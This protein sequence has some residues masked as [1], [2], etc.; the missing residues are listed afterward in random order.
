MT[1]LSRELLLLPTPWHWFVHGLGLGQ[2]PTGFDAE[3]AARIRALGRAV[4]QRYGRGFPAF[5]VELVEVILAACDPAG[6][7]GH[8]RDVCV[9][10]GERIA[11]LSNPREHARACATS[12]ESLV[13]LGELPPDNEVLRRQLCDSLARMMAL[14]APSDRARYEHVHLLANLLL[15]AAR[16]G[17]TEL[18]T[19][20]VFE[21]GARLLGPV[22]DLFYYG[23][24]A[25]TWATT[26]AAVGRR[27]GDD[28]GELL[29]RVLDRI[30]TELD[31]P[32]DRASDGAHEDRD[33]L[34]FSLFLA[35][36][37]IGMT[38][39]VDLLDYKRRWLEVAPAE[40]ASL[41]P[42]ARS[43][44]TL[45]F[46]SLLRNLGLLAHHVPDPA[47]LVRA[48]AA[49][50]LAA[51]DGYQHDDYLRCTYLVHIARQLDCLT[52]LPERIGQIL[53]ETSTQLGAP[54]PHRDTPY[55]SP[56]MFVA[57]V[58]SAMHADDW[59]AKHPLWKVDLA[60]IVRSANER[61]DDVVTIPRIGFALID[62]ALCLRAS[63]D[64]GSELLSP[65]AV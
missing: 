4:M 12:I 53:A 29:R 44:Q 8:G 17:W 36:G 64:P 50:Y 18:L 43:S 61:N 30:D 51:T 27:Q 26:L 47:A 20:T 7:R 6:R 3:R 62:A 59:E 54:S 41:N 22:D 28:S 40:L 39:R 52:Q 23:R 63:S 37:A 58:L 42:R 21:A 60:S 38:R 15:A 2:N 46:V 48:A 65:F 45:L 9:R 25:A 11:G 16:A 35:L 56:L 5:V 14:P 55:G 32:R 31:G 57:Y 24:G 49:R 1:P 33:Y 13:K 10:L 34:A 19:P